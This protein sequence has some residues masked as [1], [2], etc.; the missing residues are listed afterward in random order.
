MWL[1]TVRPSAPRWAVNTRA[2]INIAFGGA[3]TAVAKLPD[4]AEQ[5]LID[6]FAENH[7]WADSYQRTLSD[8]LLL[9]GD[10]ARSIVEKIVAAARRLWSRC[11]PRA[12]CIEPLQ[13]V[14]DL[15]AFLGL[16]GRH[17]AVEVNLHVVPK[18][19]H[20]AHRLQE[21]DRIEIVTLVGG[22]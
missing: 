15:L 6:P 18:A 21:G 12:T 11:A 1:A 4:G 8:V 9:E 19:Q 2:K 17:V 22:G 10:L 14:A 3:L 13:T 16:P 20:A 7:L 5:S